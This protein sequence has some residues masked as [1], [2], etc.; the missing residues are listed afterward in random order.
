MHK[1]DTKYLYNIIYF[2]LSLPLIIFFLGWLKFYIALP[3]TLALL[4]PL[5]FCFKH[6]YIEFSNKSLLK[7]VICLLIITIFLVLS[8]IGSIGYQN[9]DYSKHNALLRDLIN[10]K[11]PVIY[12]D[13]GLLIYYLAYYLPSALFGKLFGFNAA[14]VFMFIWAFIGLTLFL[15]LMSIYLKKISIKN[16]LIFIFFSGLDIIGQLMYIGVPLGT[17][18]IEHWSK[19]LSYQSNVTLLFWVPQHAIAGWLFTVLILNLIREE[20]K[21]IIFIYSLSLFWSPFV[22]I[23]LFPFVA[24]Y[25]FKNIKKSINIYNMFSIVIVF[26]FGMYYR[27]NNS[28]GTFKMLWQSTN[29]YDSWFVV[30]MFYVLE[31]IIYS[32][33]LSEK[34][35]KDKIFLISIVTLSLIPLLQFGMGGDFVMRASIPSLCVL[36]F[37]IIKYINENGHCKNILIALLLVGSLTG[38]FEISRSVKSFGIKCDV[39][40]SIPMA[41]NKSYSEQYISYIYNNKKFYKFFIR[42]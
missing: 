9:W 31:F 25:S 22:F 11:W 36:C 40:I 17:D 1:I 2:Y 19:I 30:L 34:F 26:I 37:F 20:N 42:K 23:G 21:Y 18:H 16:I 7:F 38:M 41:E 15:I 12:N 10:Y 14:N 33:I 8:G 39:W 24:Y 4:I 32:F 35:K 27:L 13:S 3:L 29:L 28:N 6:K 5:L